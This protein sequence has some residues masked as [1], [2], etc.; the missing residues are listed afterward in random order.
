MTV[1]KIR[2]VKHYMADDSGLR[3][4]ATSSAVGSAT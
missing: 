3:D 1:H 2:G 4:L